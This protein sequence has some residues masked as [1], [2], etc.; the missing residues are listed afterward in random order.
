VVMLCN[1]NE[2]DGNVNSECEEHEGTD[3]E[4]EA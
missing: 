4:D 2:K 3:C 1:G